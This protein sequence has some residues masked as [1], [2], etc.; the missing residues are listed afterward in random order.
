MGSGVKR[1][2]TGAFYGTGAQLDVLTVGFRP[3]I[4]HLFNVDGAD[5]GYWNDKLADGEVMKRKGVDGV[6]TKVTTNGVTPLANGFRLGADT[7]LNVDGEK[8]IYEVTD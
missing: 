3:T 7:D 8:V 2:V 6:M 5:E 1:K 4:V